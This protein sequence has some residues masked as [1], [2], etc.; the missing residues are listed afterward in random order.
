MV[1]GLGFDQSEC[2]GAVDI[3][4]RSNRIRMIQDISGIHAELELLRFANL[5]TLTDVRVETPSPG[6][7]DGLTANVSSVSGEGILENHFSARVCNSPERAELL[8][9]RRDRRALALR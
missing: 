8:Q 7:L 1:V 5:E 3:Q 4:S 2:V 6:T 9:C